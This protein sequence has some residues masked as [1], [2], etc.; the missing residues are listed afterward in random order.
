MI[1]NLQITSS[2]V[3][4][5]LTNKK[6]IVSPSGYTAGKMFARMR[7]MVLGQ[8][9]DNTDPGRLVVEFTEDGDIRYVPVPTL[10]AVSKPKSTMKKRVTFAQPDESRPQDNPPKPK[11][12]ATYHKTH[13]LCG[14]RMTRWEWTSWILVAVAWIAVILYYLVFTY[15]FLPSRVEQT[16][17]L[18]NQLESGDIPGAPPQIFSSFVRHVG[19]ES[20]WDDTECPGCGFIQWYGSHATRTVKRHQRLFVPQ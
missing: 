13:K 11:E 17:I 9:A 14:V 4:D 12:R 2:R 8:Q 15:F 1:S 19:K 10:A 3:V 7:N 18:I 20:G 16:E 5:A 6:R